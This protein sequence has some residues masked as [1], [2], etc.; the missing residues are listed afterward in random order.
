MK[1]YLLIPLSFLF[2]TASSA[3]AITTGTVFDNGGGS[4][5]ASTAPDGAGGISAADIETFLGLAPGTVD[6]LTPEPASEGSA[7]K[8]DLTVTLGDTVS[9]DWSW[10][11]YDAYDFGF[12]SFDSDAF[13]II[14]SPTGLDFSG[15]Y[16]WV[17]TTTGT[18]QFGVSAMDENGNEFDSEFTVSNISITSAP[19]PP[20]TGAPEPSIIALMGLGMIGM[21]GAVRRKRSSKHS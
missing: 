14:D 1:K 18:V 3:A 10:H 6:G 4:Y 5:T 21:F 17:A 11:T 15:S 7:F 20:P 13:L 9:F 8:Q 2:V 16:S 12:V 19:P